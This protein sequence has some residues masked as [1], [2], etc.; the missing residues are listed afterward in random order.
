VGLFAK[1]KARKASRCS[2]PE[3]TCCPA[4]A[5]SCGC[6][7]APAPSCGCDAVA[8]A[9]VSSGCSSCGSTVDSGAVISSETAAPAPAAPAAPASASDAKPAA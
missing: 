6:A 2:A 9:S 1:L 8:M 5:P 7:A 3:P 4:P